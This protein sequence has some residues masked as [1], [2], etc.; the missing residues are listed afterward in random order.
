MTCHEKI[1]SQPSCCRCSASLLA[2]L[3]LVACGPA[4]QTGGT[5]TGSEAPAAQQVGTPSQVLPRRRPRRT[6]RTCTAWPSAPLSPEECGRC[7]SY[8]YKWLK[9]KGGKHQM[10]CTTCHEQFHAYNPKLQNWDAIMP[11]CQGCHELPHGQDFAN[12][13]GM[14][15][16]APCTEGDSVRHPGKAGAGS[17]QADGGDLRDLPQEPGRRIRQVPQQAQYCASTARDATPR[18]TAPS[19]AAS[20]ATSRMWPSRNT[21]TAWSAMRRTV[22]AT[23]KNTRRRLRTPCARPAMTRLR[24]NCRPT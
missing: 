9:E 24:A 14:P 3:I 20:T 6:R 21:R 13:H 10:D 19:R 16:A 7:H 12:L 5:K 8:Q 2:S 4:G 17:R 15:S 11:K 18:Y 1:Y 22:Q 23:S